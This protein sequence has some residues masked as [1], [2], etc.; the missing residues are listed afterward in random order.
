M[1]W[2]KALKQT[3]TEST[4]ENEEK[5][6][7]AEEK[8]KCKAKEVRMLLRRAESLRNHQLLSYLRIC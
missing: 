3:N 4:T 2:W 8:V 6:T 1:N 5:K 7:A